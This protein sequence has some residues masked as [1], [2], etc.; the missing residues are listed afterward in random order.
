VTALDAVRGS[1]SARSPGAGPRVRDRSSWRVR[2][3]IQRSR[4]HGVKR[5][6]DGRYA[7]HD[8]S[9]VGTVMDAMKHVVQEQWDWE[10]TDVHWGFREDR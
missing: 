3:E 1:V 9:F 4:R 10:E 8:C 7:C 5:L 6:F 2:G